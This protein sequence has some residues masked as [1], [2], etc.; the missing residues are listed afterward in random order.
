MSTIQRDLKRWLQRV[1]VAA[2]AIKP[3]GLTEAR[4]RESLRGVVKICD[5]IRKCFLLMRL[6]PALALSLRRGEEA[7]VELAAIP[8]TEEL[9]AADKAI[10]HS[11]SNGYREGTSKYEEKFQNMVEKTCREFRESGHISLPDFTNSSLIQL[12]A[13]CVAMARLAQGDQYSSPDDTAEFANGQ[14]ARAST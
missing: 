10:I 8:D 12:Y 9:Q 2:S 3:V 13:F 11:V 6:D 5:G 4:N 7:A 14:P 1:E